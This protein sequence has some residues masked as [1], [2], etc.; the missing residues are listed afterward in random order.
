MAPYA[1]IVI[2]THDRAGTLASS[3][4]S[5]LGQTIPDIEVLI[6]GDGATAEVREIASAFERQDARVRFLDYPKAPQRGAVN[7]HRAVEE[8][9]SERIFYNDDDD[10]LLPGH[11]E[12]LGR[13]LDGADIAGTPPVSIQMDGRVALSLEDASHP[14]MRHLFVEDRHK[15]VFDTHIAHRKSSYRANAA[16]WGNAT[17]RRPVAHMLKG[18]AGNAGVTWKNVQRITALSFHGA[19][20][21]GMPE[22]ERR[23]ELEDWARQTG[24]P[25]MESELR[26]RGT[27]SFHTMKLFRALLR[28]GH[29]QDETIPA[30]I[31]G[32]P[33]NGPGL[34]AAQETD[35]AS[36][37]TLLLGQP[38]A[39]DAARRIFEDLSEA[40]LGPE[41]PAG[42]VVPLF[43]SGMTPE[44]LHGLLDRCTPS[45]AISLARF[46]LLASQGHAGA[47]D[48][49]AADLAMA[50]VPL[51]CRFFFGLSI[52][53]ALE[54]ASQPTEAW[55]RCKAMQASLP[56]NT[57]YASSYWR[58]R[59][60][61][62]NALGD[63]AEAEEARRAR[64]ETERIFD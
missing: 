15:G 46:H 55:Q 50:R 9:R 25:D 17:D 20:R 22:G 62:A 5:A 58:R 1:S 56:Q 29:L 36:I 33:G 11:V 37:R 59:E 14:L 30:T 35:I 2:P 13:E 27:Y 34:T 47:S 21:T 54:T 3:L 8:A 18:F 45:P 31:L 44:A 42:N 19:C 52:V 48:A 28:A 10:L 7:R 23:A 40:R 61:L 4:R 16:N 6:C 39:P 64:K 26:R 49:D 57:P 51:W 63:S 24:K 43:L 41:F 60:R 32:R 12:I 38:V 53:D